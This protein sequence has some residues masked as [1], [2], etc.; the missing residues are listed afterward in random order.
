MIDKIYTRS[1]WNPV[2]TYGEYIRLNI[3]R[4]VTATC[5][6]LLLSGSVTRSKSIK[7]GLMPAAL[8]GDLIL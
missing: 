6:L 7:R 2:R 4:Y 1:G 8:V 5:C 3:A